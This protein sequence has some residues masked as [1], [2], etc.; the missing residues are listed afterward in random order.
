MPKID[1]YLRILDDAN[2]THCP[3]MIEYKITF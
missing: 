3:E 2:D 1:N